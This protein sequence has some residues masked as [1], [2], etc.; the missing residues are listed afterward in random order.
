MET[1]PDAAASTPDKHPALWRIVL[2]YT[3]AQLVA[4]YVASSLALIAHLALIGPDAVTLFGTAPSNKLFHTVAFLLAT[5]LVFSIQAR[6]WPRRYW[7]TAPLI[8]VADCA[9]ASLPIFPADPH[10]PPSILLFGMRLLYCVALMTLA[11]VI[12]RPRARGV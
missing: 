10:S 12:W 8:A 1:S 5:F 11:G 9:V 6:R 3:L 2:I 7:Q 4:D